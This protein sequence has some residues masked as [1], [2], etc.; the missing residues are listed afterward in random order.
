MARKTKAPRGQTDRPHAKEPNHSP[1]LKSVK[2][3]SVCFLVA[4][5]EQKEISTDQTDQL[6]MTTNEQCKIGGTPRS[7]YDK[8]AQ[9]TQGHGCKGLGEEQVIFV[10]LHFNAPLTPLLLRLTSYQATLLWHLPIG[11]IE[12]IDPTL[13]RLSRIKTC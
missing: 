1:D 2:E 8:T 11:L 10:L 7:E 4:F 9:P 13:V 6:S 12:I 3:Y 5:S